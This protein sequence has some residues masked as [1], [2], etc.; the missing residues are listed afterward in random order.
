MVLEISVWQNSKKRLTTR[1][2]ICEKQLE[3]KNTESHETKKIWLLGAKVEEAK[4]VFD[5]F[6]C[7]IKDGVILGVLGK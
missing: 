1:I 5:I 6:K 3:E 2:N 7:V 4:G